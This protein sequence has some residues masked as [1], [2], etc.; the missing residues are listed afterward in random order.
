MSFCLFVTISVFLLPI[1]IISAYL[2]MVSYFI[3][4]VMYLFTGIARKK[5]LGG[6][7]EMKEIFQSIFIAILI[8]ELLYIIFNLIYL[9]Y[10][11]PAFWDKFQRHLMAHYGKDG[12]LNQR[13]D[14]CRK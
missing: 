3:I 6:Y 10:V 12:R 2:R 14:R 13:R 11:D 1:P 4:L 9:K 7:G 5:E 8:T